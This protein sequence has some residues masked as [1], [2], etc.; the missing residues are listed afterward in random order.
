V[1]K[2]KKEKVKKD[3]KELEELTS[4]SFFIHILTKLDIVC[5]ITFRKRRKEKCII[6]NVNVVD[7]KT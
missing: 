1:N 5:N 2:N 7:A 3:K 4:S 6:A